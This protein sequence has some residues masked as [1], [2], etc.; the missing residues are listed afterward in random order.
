MTAAAPATLVVSGFPSPTVVWTKHSL[1]V[2]ANDRYGNAATGYRGT[3]HFTSSDPKAALPANY[4]F[5]GR[6]AGVHVFSLAATLKTV[7]TRS[8]TAT[9][10]V[11][12]AIHGSQTG[13]TVTPDVARSLTVT[14]VT[15]WVAGTAHNITV[16]AG[17]AYGNTATGYT[18]TV[19]FT[20]SDPAAVLP[21]DY[22]FTASDMGV[23][24]FSFAT[25]PA[26]SLRTAG[27][28]SISRSESRE[29]M[30]QLRHRR[31]Y[32]GAR[33]SHNWTFSGSGFTAFRE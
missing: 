8:I 31:S 17:D 23:H 4:T 32:A 28:Q 3:I 9:D 33:R 25:N 18:G 20:S 13:I 16:A 30:S 24:T 26:P 22:A 7:G 21:A 2:A 19:H 29:K 1:T 15:S 27:S 10:T 14:S 6:D 11:T 12:A 5:V